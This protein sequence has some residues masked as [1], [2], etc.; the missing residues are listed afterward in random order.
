MGGGF[1]D[2]TLASWYKKYKNASQTSITKP[3]PIGLAHDCQQVDSIPN[4]CWDI[5]I[6]LIITPSQ[7]IN[8]S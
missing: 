6:P 3:Y 2:R 5:P 7:K 4:E 1:Y 8:C